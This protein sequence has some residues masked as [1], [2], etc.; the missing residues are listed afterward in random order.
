MDKYL[1]FL[2]SGFGDVEENLAKMN[3]DLKDSGV[4]KIKEELKNQ[5]NTF[6]AQK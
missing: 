6:L 4:D 1:P 2:L 3:K 5:I